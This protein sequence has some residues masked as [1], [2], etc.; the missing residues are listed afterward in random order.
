MVACIVDTTHTHT[1]THGITYIRNPLIRLGRC[2]PGGHHI[3]G[4]YADIYEWNRRYSFIEKQSR[5]AAH[6]LCTHWSCFKAVKWLLRATTLYTFTCDGYIY[7][8][9]MYLNLYISMLSVN[10]AHTSLS[11]TH[12]DVCVCCVCVY[13]WSRK[14]AGF[15]CDISHRKC[16]FIFVYLFVQ[17]NTPRKH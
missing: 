15:D 10:S 8:K 17:G 14:R 11:P 12:P 13:V 5:G 6:Q 7:V 3:S 1:H 9:R 4:A 16:K 2:P